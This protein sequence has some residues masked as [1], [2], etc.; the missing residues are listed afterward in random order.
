MHKHIAKS[1]GVER[2]PNEANK[3]IALGGGT[4]RL[5]ADHLEALSPDGDFIRVY[6]SENEP[7]PFNEFEIGE[8]S[9]RSDCHVC[10]N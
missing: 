2:C 10:N 9:C 4:L 5:C 6:A 7:L 8:Y 3:W 1:C